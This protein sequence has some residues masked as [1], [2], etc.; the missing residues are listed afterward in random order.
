MSEAGK[1]ASEPLEIRSKPRPVRRLNRKVLAVTL[2]CIA[3]VSGALAIWSFRPRLHE[4]LVSTQAQNVDR[5]THAEG[6]SRLPHD[7]G[8]V[9]TPQLGAPLGELGRPVLRAETGAGIAA[10]PERANFHPDP[11][12]DARRT[13]ALRLASEAREAGK[14]SVFFQLTEQPRAAAE[15]NAPGTSDDR[16]REELAATRGAATDAATKQAFLDRRTPG[17]IY[18]SGTLLAPRSPYELMAGTVIPAAL[19][20]GIDS[21]LPGQV[22][23]SVTENVYDTVTGRERLIPQGARLIGQY[24]S[25]VAFGQ[26]RLLLVWTRL[27]FP[28]GTSIVLDRLPGTDTE[29]H[30]GLEDRV[31]WHWSRIFEGAA[32]STLLGVAAELAVPKS[33]SGSGTVV[34]AASQGL[35]D[36][37]NQVGQQITRRNIDI[38]PTITIRPGFPIRVIV[39]R[40]LILRPYPT[41]EAGAPRS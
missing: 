2:A 39:N 28:D 13:E 36:T 14:A 35:D 15:R 16:Q 41:E 6:L 21:D 4:A 33:T 26:R 27:I 9:K 1:E 32:V 12:E 8:G 3:T 11:E 30:A 31:D 25:Q 17:G 23:A 5:V 37:V 7:Y 10:L 22:I 38:Q 20:T 34:I 24:D 40:D 18:A 19:V 29:G